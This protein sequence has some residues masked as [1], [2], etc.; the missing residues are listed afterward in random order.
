M[1]ADANPF[2]IH[3]DKLIG[4]DYSAALIH[5]GLPG[6]HVNVQGHDFRAP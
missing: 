6:V 1:S 2:S 4:A 5:R 3:R